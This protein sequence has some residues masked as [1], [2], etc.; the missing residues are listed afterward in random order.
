M[1]LYQQQAEKSDHRRT[2]AGISN[3]CTDIKSLHALADLVLGDGEPKT[4]SEEKCR[5]PRE[6]WVKPAEIRQIS[7]STSGKNWVNTQFLPKPN[8]EI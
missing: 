2:R 8:E 4:R 1:R 3:L 6:D 5:D 7:T